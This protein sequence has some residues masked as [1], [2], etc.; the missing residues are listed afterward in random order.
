MVMTSA[1]MNV[2]AIAASNK[3]SRRWW[4]AIAATAI[5]DAAWMPSTSANQRA[6]WGAARTSSS[7]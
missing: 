3:A 1:T 5:M 6:R 7:A 2:D 4:E